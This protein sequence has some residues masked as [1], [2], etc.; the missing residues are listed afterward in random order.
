MRQFRK[1]LFWSFY[2]VAVATGC[3]Y[4]LFPSERVSRIM[5]HQMQQLS[6]DSRL[7]V[8]NI[9]PRF[10]PAIRIDAIQ[11][12]FRENLL[13]TLESLN[14]EPKWRNLFSEE[15]RYQ[16]RGTLAQGNVGGIATVST[17]PG[18]TPGIR[19]ATEFSEVHLED[20][21]LWKHYGRF[22]LSGRLSGRGEFT[23]NGFQADID[24]QNASVNNPMPFFNLDR[25]TFPSISGRAQFAT[26]RFTFSDYRLKGD[27]LQA[28]FEGIWEMQTV[29]GASRF[30]LSGRLDPGPY[31]MSL[32]KRLMPAFF[33]RG[34]ASEE[35]FFFNLEGNTGKAKIILK[36]GAETQAFPLN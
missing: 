23:S 30:S 29:P 16:Y 25:F 35:P 36:R 22:V 8:G 7:I 18:E 27:Q 28:E 34:I 9:T 24:I 31:L 10:P 4:F 26:N 15:N 12:M 19:V 5:A 21:S 32:M 17:P 20:L 11:C 14:I 2:C 1:L 33:S 13:F 3:L 6:S